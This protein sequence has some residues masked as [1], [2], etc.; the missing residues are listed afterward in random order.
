[1]HTATLQTNYV[2]RGIFQNEEQPMMPDMAIYRN[3]DDFK[4]Q[5][6]FCSKKIAHIFN[7]NRFIKEN[8]KLSQF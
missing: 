3:F 5:K 8:L 1:M 4:Y 6:D 7:K 2:C